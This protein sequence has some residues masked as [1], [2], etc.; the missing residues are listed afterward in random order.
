MAGRDVLKSLLHAM[1][2]QHS[3]SE[4][5]AGNNVDDAAA[6]SAKSAAAA[7]AVDKWDLTQSVVMSKLRSSHQWTHAQFPTFIA[8]L[9][10]LV[11]FFFVFDIAI[12]LLLYV[13]YMI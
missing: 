7:A 6:S 12:C 3:L 8:K 2:F 1:K 5:D 9:D 13:R 10:S 4:L 11:L